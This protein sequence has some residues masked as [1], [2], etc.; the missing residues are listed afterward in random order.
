MTKCKIRARGVRTRFLLRVHCSSSW[1]KHSAWSMPTSNVFWIVLSRYS[2][3][4]SSTVCSS[5]SDAYL[6]G[7]EKSEKNMKY[8]E[9]LS[10][11]LMNFKKADFII[12]Y[13]FIRYIRAGAKCYATNKIFR[14][15]E[16]LSKNN[17]AY[18]N[19]LKVRVSF[20]LISSC[21][22]LCSLRYIRNWLAW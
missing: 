15:L 7:G 18:R 1:Y 22:I 17:S 6:S 2:R 13:S 19:Y 21:W 20:S 10:L 9:C 3:I 8:I 5:P 4:D 12:H 16:R 14:Y 11:R